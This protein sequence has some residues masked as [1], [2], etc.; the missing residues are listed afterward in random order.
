LA[1]NDDCITAFG[2][3]DEE[4]DDNLGR[5]GYNVGRGKLYLG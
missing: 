1:F 2:Y 3:F 5:H 4:T